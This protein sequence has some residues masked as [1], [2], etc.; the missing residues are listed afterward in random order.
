MG[1]NAKVQECKAMEGLVKEGGE[2]IEA[3][4]VSDR[5][6]LRIRRRI[7]LTVANA[8]ATGLPT[9]DYRVTLIVTCAPRA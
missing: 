3:E 7:V 2:V 1:Q 9:R 5:R 6:L 8:V 4:T